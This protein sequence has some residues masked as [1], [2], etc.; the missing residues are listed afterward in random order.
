VLPSFFVYTGFLLLLVGALSLIRPLQ[1]LGIRSRRSAGTVLASGLLLC[2]VGFAY[3][4]TEK[5]ALSPQS[6]L[7]RLMP[8]WHFDEHHSMYVDAPPDRVFAAIRQV[9]AN[10]ILLFK[11]LTTIRRFGRAGPE[12]ILNA[13]ETKPIIDVATSTTFARLFDQPPNELVVGTIVREPPAASL[14]I[15]TAEAFRMKL[16]PGYAIAA[17]NFKVAPAGPNRSL[18]WTETRV[19]ATDKTARRAFSIYWRLIHPGSDIIRRMWLRA[20]KRRAERSP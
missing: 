18:V 11:T 14:D 3:P 2:I 15:N 17:M 13:P 12:H 19:Y 16:P 4:V 1:F 20:V 10:E 9:R 7:D 6:E 5:R 8:V